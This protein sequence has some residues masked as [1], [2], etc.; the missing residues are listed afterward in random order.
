MNPIVEKI[1]YILCSGTAAAALTF[2]LT[3]GKYASEVK[4]LNAEESKI[5]VDEVNATVELWQKMVAGLRKDVQ[6]LT[7]EL[8][9][10][11]QSN[12][13]MQTKLAKIR[14]LLKAEGK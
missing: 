13:K 8:E 1:L 4:K 14:T 11:R 3:R 7:A 5:N 6:E 10:V 9:A 12:R 2:L